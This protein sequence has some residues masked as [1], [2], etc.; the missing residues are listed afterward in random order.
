MDVAMTSEAHSDQVIRTVCPAPAFQNDVMYLEVYWIEAP[1][2][3]TAPTAFH[4]N[5]GRDRFWDWHAGIISQSRH[6]IKPPTSATRHSY[7]RE[8]SAITRRIASIS[9]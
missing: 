1:T 4:K 5:L 9:S 2:D 6:G 7:F 8:R 3:A